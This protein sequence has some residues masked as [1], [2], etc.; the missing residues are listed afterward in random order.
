VQTRN[1][2]E[3]PTRGGAAAAAHNQVRCRRSSSTVRK[4]H[5]LAAPASLLAEICVDV[6]VLV[7][8][9][10]V[11]VLV[12]D[13]LEWPCRAVGDIVQTFAFGRL[14]TKCYPW[15]RRLRGRPLAH[16]FRKQVALPQ[17][18]ALRSRAIAPSRHRAYAPPLGHVALGHRLRGGE[19]IRS[20]HG[21]GVCA[22]RDTLATG[23]PAPSGRPRNRLATL[24]SGSQV[25]GTTRIR[26]DASTASSG[27][28][29]ASR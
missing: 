28:R 4:G 16:Q 11:M 29:I 8:K 5:V 20:V 25:L 26:T 19:M 3:N 9:P 2:P 10:T 22:D 12:L 13:E 18:T 6:N 7:T 17:A 21:G 14:L 15:T 24:S 1:C 27:H 23:R